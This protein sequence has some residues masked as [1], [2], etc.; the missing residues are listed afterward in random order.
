M[1]SFLVACLAVAVIGILAAVIL[2]NAVQEPASAA[3]STT[4]VRL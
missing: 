3:F 1:R 4:A 2:V